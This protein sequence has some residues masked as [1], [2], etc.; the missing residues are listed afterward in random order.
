MV[1]HDPGPWFEESLSSLAAQDYP[2]L[3]V[4]VIDAGATAGVEQRVAQVLPDASVAPLLS[5]PGFARAANQMLDADVRSP[6]LF[7]CHDDVA[8]A[9][10]AIRR[11]LEEA[12]RSNA[13]VVGPKLVDWDDE[14]RILE[15]G[16]TIDKTVATSHYVE[17]L[18][19]DQQQ[20]DAVRDVFAVSDAAML[21]RSDLF[22]A[23][24]GFD[25]GMPYAGGDTDL[26]WRA[27]IAGA[28]VMVAPSAVVRHRRAMT[29]EH[30]A[31]AG[32]ESDGPTRLQRRHQVRMLLSNYTGAHTARV[33][34]QALLASLATILRAL[35]RGRWQRVSNEVTAW[36]WNLTNI[37]GILARRGQVSQLRRVSDTDVRRFHT[38]GFEAINRYV[39]RRGERAGVER[40]G[41]TAEL[42]ALSSSVPGQ[43]TLGIWTSI[44]ALICFGSRSLIQEGVPLVNDLV[45]IP[46]DSSSLFSA[47]WSSL[48]PGALGAEGFGATGLG[49]LGLFSIGTLGQAGFLRLLLT[50]GMV[51][52]GA[53][54]MVRFVA[55]FRSVA[56]RALAPWV[57]VSLPLPYNAL[58][59]GSW[60]GLVLFGSL[61]WIMRAISRAA[62]I[63][64]HESALDAKLTRAARLRLIVVAGVICAMAA[65]F[66]PFVL[67]IVA[68]VVVSFALGT[69]LAG[70]FSGIPGALGAGFGAVAIAVV[71]HL[72]WSTEFFGRSGWSMFAGTRSSDVGEFSAHE[73]LRL[74]TGPHGGGFLGWAIIVVAALGLLLASGERL[75]WAIRGWVMV[76]VSVVVAWAEQIALFDLSLPAPEVLLAPAALGLGLSASMLIIAVERDLGSYQFGFR[77]LLLPAIAVVALVA[78]AVAGLGASVQGRW[79]A[80]G[81]GYETAVRF[82]DDGNDAQARVLWVGEDDVVSARG[83]PWRGITIAATS[84][85]APS[86]EDYWTTLDPS[87]GDT[88]RGALDVAVDGGTNRLG[89]LLAPMG[90]RYIVVVERNAPAP[91]GER[92]HLVPESVAQGLREQLDFE[93]VEVREG[94]TVFRNTSWLPIAAQLAEGSSSRSTRL[95]DV[96]AQA[97]R[98]GSLELAQWSTSGLVPDSPTRW[99]GLVPAGREVHVAAV[100]SGNWRLDDDTGTAVR[101]T[102]YGWANAFRPPA[103]GPV[104]LTYNT[105]LLHR[106]ALLG[107]V[108]LWV[109]AIGFAG[110]GPRSRRTS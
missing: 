33:L 71:L 88:L 67:F 96:A 74:A 53:V 92:E 26:C 97:A 50:L 9:P 89:G 29:T 104:V 45:A 1:T 13:G 22:A 4:I 19:F 36:L 56:A 81:G 42:I 73:L 70:R 35:I 94:M 58:S 107:Q 54:G 27:H 101:T 91:F 51:G 40:S 68:V 16:V 48:R 2:R 46:E 39:Q 41:R 6:Y 44:A 3:Q 93:R 63:D 65:A 108:A 15:V 49:L 103:G 30:A 34:P 78:T 57:Y 86:V 5:N 8:L 10:D 7:F 85:A 84:A 105:P 47:W 43:I 32:P 69:L 55:P 38:N 80:P 99:E 102:G 66:E 76:V 90:I 72:P 12:L 37:G 17:P 62:G 14:R 100:S 109:L 20:H 75:V 31:L 23:L 61:P 87:A 60:G 64:P 59:N 106:L 28:K 21:V 110:F 25:P 83:W 18:E 77:Q 95:V 98:I 79:D 24:G 52:F 82:L 11:M